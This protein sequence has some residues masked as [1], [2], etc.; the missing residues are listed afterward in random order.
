MAK[1]TIKPTPTSATEFD[2]AG[3]KVTLLLFRAVAQKDRQKIMHF[4]MNNESFLVKDLQ[5]KT[6]LMPA[7]LS[8]YLTILKSAKLVTCKREGRSFRYKVNPPVVGKLNA[9]LK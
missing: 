8:Q 7:V 1:A 2:R 5:A 6:K 9:F 4:L 3:I